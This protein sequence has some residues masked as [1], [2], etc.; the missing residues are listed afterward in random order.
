MTILC[1]IFVFFDILNSTTSVV[2]YTVMVILALY[3]QS[4]QLR[5]SPPS[6][7]S[8]AIFL[9]ALLCNLKMTL[10]DLIWWNDWC[11]FAL[12]F[13]VEVMFLILFLLVVL[14]CSGYVQVSGFLFSLS[15]SHTLFQI[16][17]STAVSLS[18]T[19]PPVICHF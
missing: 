19:D 18:G 15:Y 3:H 5:K 2:N 7:F 8:W 6:H 14:L 1:L 9:V 12:F 10:K 17:P 4:I 13:F 16:W 11:L